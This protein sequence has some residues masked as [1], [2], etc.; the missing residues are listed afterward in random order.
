MQCLRCNTDNEEG[1]RF[2][3]NCGTDL[4][5]KPAAAVKDNGASQSMMYVL[6]LLGWDYFKAIGW[7]LVRKLSTVADFTRLSLIYN[8]TNWI[9]DGVSLVLLIVFS[10]L[11]KNNTARIFLIIFTVL[12]FL[13]MLSVHFF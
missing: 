6:I 13:L 7:L 3:K 11:V 2:C 10:I 4:W 8:V 5:Y 12:H 1:A 9:F